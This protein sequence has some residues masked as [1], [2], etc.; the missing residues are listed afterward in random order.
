VPAKRPLRAL[1]A[2]GDEVPTAELAAHVP[3]DHPDV[4]AR[5]LETLKAAGAKQQA[6]ELAA[7]AAT[8]VLLDAT[9]R[10]SRLLKAL[11]EMGA[12]RQVRVL[13]DRL[14]AEG[15]FALFCEQADHGVTYRFGREPDGRPA[16]AWGWEDLNWPAPT[17]GL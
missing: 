9:P 14:P 12:E 1:K 16:S 17:Q 2:A 10:V 13:T 8:G 5:L 6:A 3:L 11:R 15:Y 7:R 4:I